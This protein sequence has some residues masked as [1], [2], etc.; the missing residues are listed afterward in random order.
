MSLWLFRVRYHDEGPQD[1]EFQ[2][3]RNDQLLSR[4][5]AS[6][7]RCLSAPGRAGCDFINEVLQE[8]E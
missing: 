5:E 6:Q 8:V 2:V 7:I 3:L 4:D 1:D